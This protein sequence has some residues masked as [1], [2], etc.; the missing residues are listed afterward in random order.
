VRRRAVRARAWPLPDPA[1]RERL[2][3]R[4]A[5]RRRTARVQRGRA[6]RRPAAEPA[7]SAF[8]T[9]FRGLLNLFDDQ[10]RPFGDDCGAT[11]WGGTLYEL[12]PGT[13]SPYHWQMGEE[14]CCVVI[15]GTPTLRTP[16]GERALE[17]W[18]IAW[19]SRGPAGAH[20]LRNDTDEPA[21]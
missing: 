11:L 20:G 16:E 17:P 6:A 8:R 12:A 9:G 4:W 5:E 7:G 15:S 1:S 21:R 18:D 14:E 19:F 10:P 2:L 3:S 13:S